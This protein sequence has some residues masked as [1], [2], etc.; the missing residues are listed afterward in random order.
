M[1]AFCT[2]HRYLHRCTKLVL[3]LTILLGFNFWQ[4]NK[5][6]NADYT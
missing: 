1:K 2:V 5:F 6:K 4:L 3:R